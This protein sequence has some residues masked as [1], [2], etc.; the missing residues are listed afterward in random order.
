M[1]LGIIFVGKPWKYSIVVGQ[2]K[3]LG[4]EVSANGE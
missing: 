1:G 4:R 3:S 2:K